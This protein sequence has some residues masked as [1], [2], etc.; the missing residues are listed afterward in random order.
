MPF[1]SVNL[2]FLSLSFADRLIMAHHG[3]TVNREDRRYLMWR[4]IVRSPLV[5][6][7]FNKLPDQ[8]VKT[9][10]WDLERKIKQ[11]NIKF[12]QFF[13]D[14][15]WASFVKRVHDAHS[16]SILLVGHF[17]P[18]SPIVIKYDSTTGIVIPAWHNAQAYL[19]LDDKLKYQF[20]SF[21][22]KGEYSERRC[23]SGAP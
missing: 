6:Y 13:P 11:T 23:T 20:R 19:I 17:H 9:I 4:K 8:K 1:D 3:D 14:D 7:I 21:T 16:P 5:K 10:L 2:E 18:P 22:P 15:Q 12:K